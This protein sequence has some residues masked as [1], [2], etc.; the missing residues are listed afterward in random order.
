MGGLPLGRKDQ[1]VMQWKAVLKPVI[2]SDAFSQRR[3]S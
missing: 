2:L 1:L 3:E